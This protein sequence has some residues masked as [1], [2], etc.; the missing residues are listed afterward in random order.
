[1]FKFMMLIILRKLMIIIKYG[2]RP[3]LKDNLKWIKSL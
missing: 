3:K 2:I 1:M